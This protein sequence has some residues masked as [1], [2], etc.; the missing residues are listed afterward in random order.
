MLAGV[1][2]HNPKGSSNSKSRFF[3]I[4]F[5]LKLL[6]STLWGDLFLFFMCNRT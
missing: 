4:E 1:F 2:A 3:T 6:R 5:N